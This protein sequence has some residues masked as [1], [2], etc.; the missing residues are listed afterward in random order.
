[1]KTPKLS[2]TTDAHAYKKEIIDSILETYQGLP[3][4]FYAHSLF[5]PVRAK[6]YHLKMRFP[7]SDTV[8]RYFRELRERGVIK[9][10]CV[11]RKSSL[12]SKC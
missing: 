5:T 6:V 12:Y 2:P 7:Y 9:C 4:E 1:M 8:L 11:N 10:E 3:N